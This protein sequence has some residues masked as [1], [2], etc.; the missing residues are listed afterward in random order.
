MNPFE[1]TFVYEDFVKGDCEKEITEIFGE[2]EYERLMK[3]LKER[4]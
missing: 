4:C 2:V 3:F 1:N